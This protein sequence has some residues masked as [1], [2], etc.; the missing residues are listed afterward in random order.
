MHAPSLCPLCPL[1]CYSGGRT[2]N[3][4]RQ[5]THRQTEI[6]SRPVKAAAIHLHPNKVSICEHRHLEI[7]LSTLLLLLLVVTQAGTSW[8]RPSVRHCPSPHTHTHD[9][10][11]VSQANLIKFKKK[12]RKPLVNWRGRR[13]RG[14]YF[15]CHSPPLDGWDLHSLVWY[16]SRIIF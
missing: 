6:H 10:H 1:A 2:L 16:H 13:G 8:K 14:A 12:K 15:A 11:C 5:Q 3:H 9:Y 4:V 7:P